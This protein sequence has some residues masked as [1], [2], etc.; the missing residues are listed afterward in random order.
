MINKTQTAFREVSM[1]RDGALPTQLQSRARAND[2]FDFHGL[3]LFSCTNNFVH[4]ILMCIIVL[5]R[6]IYINIPAFTNE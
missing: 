2:N 1:W 6:K 4:I 5:E 3:S